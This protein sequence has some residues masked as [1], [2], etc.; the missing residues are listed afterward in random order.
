VIS[1]RWA[2]IKGP[3]DYS[4]WL[5]KDRSLIQAKSTALTPSKVGTKSA[6]ARRKGI[7]TVL[8]PKEQV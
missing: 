8:G 2:N 4:K 3:E 5:T 6:G 7:C 1:A